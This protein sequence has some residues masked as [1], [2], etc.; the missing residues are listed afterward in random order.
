MSQSNSFREIQEADHSAVRAIYV[1]AINF[2]AIGLY[3]Q[4]QIDAWSSLAVLPGILD[5]TLLD[6]KGWLSLENNEIAAFAVRHPDYRLALLYCKPSF[7]R[8]GHATKLLMKVERDAFHEGQE[9]LVTEASLLSYP[10]LLKKGWIFVK[11]DDI[12]I[13]GVPFQRC[14]MH[15]NL[16]K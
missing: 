12:E 9:Y 5:R 1:D 14:I 2:L 10:I 15:K 8:R 11:I 7:S 16:T 6:G 13:N 3:S 4:E